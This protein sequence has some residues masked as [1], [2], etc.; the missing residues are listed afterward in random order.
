[1]RPDRL[2]QC[3]HGKKTILKTDPGQGKVREFS[4]CSESFENDLNMQVKVGELA[5]KCFGSFSICCLHMR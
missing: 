3:C 1:M 4:P 5:N 2:V